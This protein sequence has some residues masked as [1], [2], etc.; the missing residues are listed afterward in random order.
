MNARGEGA[1]ALGRPQGSRLGPT[2][3]G[4]WAHARGGGPRCPNNKQVS[5]KPTSSVPRFRGTS[6]TPM[7][8]Q[9][10]GLQQAHLICAPI[11]GQARHPDAR[12]TSKFATGPPDSYPVFG[13]RLTPRC[14][15]NKQVCTVSGSASGRLARDRS[16]MMVTFLLRDDHREGWQGTGAP[17]W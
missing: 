11:L 8:Q 1:A 17:L 14:P 2:P 13:A 7:L 15:N 3:S 9:Q 6:D 12:T 16:A 4:P 5:N 10:A